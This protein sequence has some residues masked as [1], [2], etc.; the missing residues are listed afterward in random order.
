MSQFYNCFHVENTKDGIVV[1]IIG[2]KV[3]L[4]EGHIQLINE[5]LPRL[6]REYGTT[7][8]IFNLQN[9]ECVAS[10]TIGYF[11]RIHQMVEDL[12][13]KFLLEGVSPHIGE[14]LEMSGVGIDFKYSPTP[15][16]AGT[17][18]VIH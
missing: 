13:G 4:M 15:E 14:I 7:K 10:C 17:D 16:L 9:V 5:E 6:I 1:S 2:N 8:I 12:G 11:F 3:R 18:P